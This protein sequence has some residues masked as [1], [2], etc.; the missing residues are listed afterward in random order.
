MTSIHFRNFGQFQGIG[1]LSVKTETSVIWCFWWFWQPNNNSSSEFPLLLQAYFFNAELFKST[2]P[3]KL[4]FI[5]YHHLLKFKMKTKLLTFCPKFHPCFPS[6]FFT[7]ISNLKSIWIP[8]PRLLRQ[9]DDILSESASFVFSHHIPKLSF[10]L[11]PALTLS[12][13][14]L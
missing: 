1:E 3:F 10:Y 2:Y 6:P 4:Q 7:R 13:S 9:K 11:F 8:Y 14:E 5:L 12:F